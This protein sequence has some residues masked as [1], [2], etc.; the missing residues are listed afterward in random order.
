ML[1]YYI[2]NIVIEQR[3]EIFKNNNTAQSELLKILDNLHKSSDT[4]SV[5]K[6]LFGDIDLSILKD[7]GFKNLN[8][9]IFNKGSITS[10]T[11]V[12][13][14][15]TELKIADNLLLDIKNLPN[16]LEILDI[17]NNYVS[18]IDF[19]ELISIKKINIS[20]NNFE[21][22]SNLPT[23]ITHIECN[24]NKITYI[25]L[26]EL[27]SLEKLNASNNKLTVIDNLPD[28]I[29]ELLLENNPNIQYHNTNVLPQVTEKESETNYYDCLN[30]Y[31]KLKND[32]ETKILKSKRKIYNDAIKKGSGKARAKKLISTVKPTCIY[33]KKDVGTLFTTKN[34]VHK[35]IC[36]DSVNPC[37]L[38]IEIN[39][40]DYFNLIE[41]IQ[42]YS[43]ILRDVREDI[44]LL[45]LDSLFDYNSKDVTL[46]L[47]NK[48]ME[49]Y[50]VHSEQFDNLMDRYN[51][52][53][54]LN[55]N[56]NKEKYLQVKENMKNIKENTDMAIKLINDYKENNN[57]ELLIQGLSTYIDEIIPKVK[58]NNLLLFNNIYIDSTDLNKDTLHTLVKEKVSYSNLEYSY[59]QK[60]YVKSFKIIPS[61]DTP[62]INN[63]NS[64]TPILD[65]LM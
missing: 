38:L 46:N 48:K 33:C 59:G 13:T 1:K 16:T 40:G 15:I 5:N 42:E 53:F 32:Y 24:N 3:E 11:N 9:I 55:E 21:K 52:L 57:K 61:G 23:T 10:I 7:Y 43:E 26:F 19:S 44:I 60:P 37:P 27:K 65:R 36:G 20:H 28:N 29:T 22:L 62:V 17:E 12:P 50:S 45:K 30:Q 4:L 2:M 34:K 47:Y 18:N 56:Y 35:A 31:F 6:S 51:E 39:T 41:Y 63:D 8:K 64:L 25:N 58:N 54:E 49:E 14:N